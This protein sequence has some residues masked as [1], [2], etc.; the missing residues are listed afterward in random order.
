MIQADL[1]RVR[2]VY[3]L[4]RNML[5][6]LAFLLLSTM[7][8]LGLTLGYGLFADGARKTEEMGHALRASIKGLMLARDAGTIQETIAGLTKPPSTIARAFIINTNDLVVFSSDAAD[9]GR[10][11][12]VRSEEACATCHNNP[13]DARA[14]HTVRTRY[15]GAEV[16]RN[17]TAFPNETACQGCHG[18]ASANAGV[19]VIDRELGET[20]RLIGKIELA[21]AA[22]GLM[23]I[24][25]LGFLWNRSANRFAGGILRREEELSSLYAV[26]NRLSRSIHVEELETTVVGILQD[27]LDARAVD[28]V[29]PRPDN[30]FRCVTWMPNRAQGLRNKID[31]GS[32]LEGRILRW[33]ERPLPT[34]ITP[35]AGEVHLAIHNEG[36]PLV[37]ILVHRPATPLAA[38]G[39]RLIA[40][41]EKHIAVAFENARL[42]TEAVTDVLT[43]LYTRRHFDTIFHARL[44]Q[45][46]QEGERLC[47]MMIDVDRF[48]EINDRFGHL[49]GDHVLRSVGNGISGLI[50]SSDLAFRYGGDELAV[51]LPGAGVSEG[52]LVAERLR[53]HIATIDFGGPGIVLSLS[54][55]LAV[56]PV[57]GDTI[58][59]IFSAADQALYE[60]KRLGRNRVV[61]ARG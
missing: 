46:R 5:L 57:N 58:D 21:V 10:R 54:I 40:V 59:R 36:I 17:V 49:V 25:V 48:K 55:G 34:E 13:V 18:T 29:L 43:G 6:G 33:L 50:R 56:A 28:I 41:L 24:L 26:V 20:Y 60:A 38:A 35:D 22:T 19:L 15:K 52:F 51:L 30:N 3:P 42:Y 37:Y 1:S 23:S 27:L 11:F 61:A 9:I 14:R 12:D 47:L 45:A 7:I 2:W 4:K 32:P 44:A 53:E 16:L 39:E 8:F 31:A